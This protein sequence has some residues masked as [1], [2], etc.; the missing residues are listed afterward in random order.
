MDKEYKFANQVFECDPE[1]INP[2]EIVKRVSKK[3]LVVRE[4]TAIED[5]SWKPEFIVGG[6]GSHCTNNHDQKWNIKPNLDN[7]FIR[8]RL[9]KNKG[10]RDKWGNRFEIDYQPRKKYDY[11]F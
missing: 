4:M 8:I 9:S 11:N 5:E 1:A 2:Y 6:F 7:P 10:W 3:T